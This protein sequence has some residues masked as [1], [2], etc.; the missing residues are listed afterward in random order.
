M[1]FLEIAD[2]LAIIGLWFVVPLITIRLV[3]AIRAAAPRW[4]RQVTE[5]VQ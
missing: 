3:N 1:P 2:F 5:A 4:V